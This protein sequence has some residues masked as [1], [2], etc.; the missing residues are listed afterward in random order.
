MTWKRYLKSL[1]SVSKSFFKKEKLF[2][3]ILYGSAVKGKDEPRD[4]DIVLIFFDKGFKERLDISYEFKK[5]LPKEL[6]F[7]VKSINMADFYDSGFFARQGILIEGY[8]LVSGKK[9]SEKLGFKGYSLFS[10]ALGNLNNNQKT[11]FTYS[12]IG[13]GKI[14]GMVKKVA[15]Q[16]IGRGAFLV[17]IENSILFE[18]FLEKWNV[19][20]IKKNTLIAQ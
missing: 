8:S 17:P 11:L 19:K 12:L 3:I 5:R 2:D 20:Y 18:Q 16:S 4:I 9:F 14:D 6:K 10:Y 1:E 15:G 7:D 13:R